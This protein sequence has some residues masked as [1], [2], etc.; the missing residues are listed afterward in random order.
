MTTEGEILVAI[1]LSGVAYFGKKVLWDGDLWNGAD[2]GD[3]ILPVIIFFSVW[4]RYWRD[5]RRQGRN[6]KIRSL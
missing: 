3:F 2:G 5:K 6:Y 1:V 4:F